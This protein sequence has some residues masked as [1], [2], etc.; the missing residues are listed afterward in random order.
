MAK[1]H[2]KFKKGTIVMNLSK[3]LYTKR[4]LLVAKSLAIFL[5][6][7]WY[8]ALFIKVEPLFVV[9]L[10]AKRNLRHR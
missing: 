10:I 1:R 5:S 8:L 3:C 2:R 6:F 7:A 9:L 4:F